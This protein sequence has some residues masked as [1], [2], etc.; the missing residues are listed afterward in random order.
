MNGT[1]HNQSIEQIATEAAQWLSEVEN[2]D[3]QTRAAFVSWVS[4]SRQ[5]LEEFFRMAELDAALV[6]V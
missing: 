4:T 6:R 3:E 5:H 2:A 1:T